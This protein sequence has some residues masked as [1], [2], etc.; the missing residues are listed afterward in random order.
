[1]KEK[2]TGAHLG[3]E[4]VSAGNEAHFCLLWMVD[5]EKRR[6]WDNM[7]SFIRDGVTTYKSGLAPAAGAVHGSGLYRQRMSEI[8]HLA[9]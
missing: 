6:G 9:P 3:P 1:M 8:A 2:K 5:G 7:R 4:S